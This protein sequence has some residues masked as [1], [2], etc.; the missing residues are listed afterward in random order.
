MHCAI[1]FKKVLQSTFL[2]IIK[3]CIIAGNFLDSTSII[4]M[5]GINRDVKLKILI[6]VY[7]NLGVIL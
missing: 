2:K 3:Q 7:F 1:I 6:S 5:H 4:K